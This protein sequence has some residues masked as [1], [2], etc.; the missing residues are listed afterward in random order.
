[1]AHRLILA[2]AS[3]A[4]LSSLRNAGLDPEV[5]VS[6][7]D[8]DSIHDDRPDLLA[9]VLAEAKGAAVLEQVQGDV[10]LVACDSVL[11]FE[12][13]A[14]GKPGTPEHALA[15]WHRIRG[16]QGVL[17]T[18]HFV[19]V[20]RG[21]RLV[22]QSRIAST[23]VKFGDLTEEEIR[24]YVATGEPLVVAGGFTIDGFGGAFI[25]GVEG[26]PHNVIG[27]SL[28]L[29]RQ[30]LLDLGIPWQTLWRPGLSID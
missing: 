1:M 14:H 19:V 23:I 30:M 25:T 29:L 11:E 13:R 15:Q 21:D 4:R 6:G 3:P 7:I 24:A 12:G 8:E 27:I 5:I 22:E 16:G 28:P 20:R 18:G 17:H 2:S 9:R 26:D 10:V